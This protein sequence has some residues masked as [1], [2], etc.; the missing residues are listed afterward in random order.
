MGPGVCVIVLVAS[1]VA[2]VYTYGGTT[3]VHTGDRG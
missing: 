2:F 1:E 3:V